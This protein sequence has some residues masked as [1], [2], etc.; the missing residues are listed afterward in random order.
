MQAI[1]LTAWN[2]PEALRTLLQSL[3]QVR[4]LEHW[5][6][7]V[8][9]EPSPVQNTL[10]Q[11][12]HDSEMPCAV[13]VT[14]NR[15]QLG[16]RGNPLACLQQAAAAGAQ[17][18]LLLEDDLEVSQDCLEF[19]EL[20]MAFPDWDNHFSCGNLHFSTCFNE[21]HLQRWDSDCADTASACLETWFLSSL[22][23]FFSK[24]QLE[25]FIAPHWNDAPLQLRSFEGDAV[26]G[27][28]CALKQALLLSHQPCLQSLLPRV[29]HL[30]IEGVHSNAE[31][32]QR[33]Y[34]HA[35]IHSGL[36][37]LSQLKRHSIDSINGSHAE[38][39]AWGA[40]LRMGAQLWTLERTALLR[41]RELAR[42]SH[43]L[44]QISPWLN[45]DSATA[46]GDSPAS[47]ATSR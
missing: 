18:F 35:G 13:H 46:T 3:R 38:A 24:A 36:Q 37:P 39:T 44:A 31:L 42:C 40:L 14:Q 17:H 30:G 27:W 19:I 33:S 1:G 22:G 41:Q 21:A 12:I 23:L 11:L 26:S 4:R 25:R 28:D 29:R 32:F 6:L 34:A 45:A 9:L 5:Q 20:A 8:H 43:Q 2:R 16:V 10:H 47:Q 7:F 15:T